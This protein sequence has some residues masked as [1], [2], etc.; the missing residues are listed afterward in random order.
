M[1]LFRHRV[2][3]AITGIALITLFVYAVRDAQMASVSF[4]PGDFLLVFAIYGIPLL[5]FIF[6]VWADG[7]N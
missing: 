2:R 3:L 6:M 1:S 5:V 7:V 4:D